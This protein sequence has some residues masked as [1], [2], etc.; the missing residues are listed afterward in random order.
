MRPTSYPRTQGASLGSMTGGM[1]PE[2]LDLPPLDQIGFVVRDMD[3]AL[4]TYGPLFGP[5]AVFEMPMTGVDYRGR[6]CDCRI[7]IALGR[8]GTLEVE[9][10]ELLDGDALYAEFLARGLEGVHH[11][12]T[13]VPNMD[14]ALAE[15]AKV[16][17]E[18]VFSGDLAPIPMLFAYLEGPDGTVLELVAP[19]NSVE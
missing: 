13:T 10:I 18:P 12:R 5:F 6:K 9:L 14:A 2:H 8:S 16:G 19:S 4:A 15:C 17:F 3:E 1:I 7:K 11:V